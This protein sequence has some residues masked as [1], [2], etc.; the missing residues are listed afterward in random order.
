MPQNV[1][2][3][4]PLVGLPLHQQIGQA[5][6]L[7]SFNDLKIIPRGTVVVG[8]E[9]TELGSADNPPTIPTRKQDMMPDD[10]SPSRELLTRGEAVD[11]T[12]AIFGAAVLGGIAYGILARGFQIGT[13]I[14][15]GGAGWLPVGIVTIGMLAL[16]MVIFRLS[17]TTRF[18]TAG[19]AIAVAPATGGIIA[20]EIFITWGVSQIV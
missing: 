8:P 5:S 6:L 1:G 7:D 9:L 2:Q 15:N 20:L 10:P 4:G 13:P 16:G 11:W 17:R 19:A 12:A 3:E 14:G 18:R